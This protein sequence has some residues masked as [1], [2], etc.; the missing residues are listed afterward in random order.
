MRVIPPVA[1]RTVELSA[2]EKAAIDHYAATKGITPDEA[3]TELARTAL[4][5]RYRMPRVPGVV[6]PMRRR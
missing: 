3:A 6:L 1:T 4:D 2:A 5:S